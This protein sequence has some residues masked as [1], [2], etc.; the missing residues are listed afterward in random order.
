MAE[1]VP[2]VPGV[3]GFVGEGGLFA[4]RAYNLFERAIEV[5][6]RERAGRAATG[7]S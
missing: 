6:R 7:A 3:P 1:P 4:R 5:T 2:G